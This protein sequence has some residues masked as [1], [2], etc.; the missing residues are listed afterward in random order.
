MRSKEDVTPVRSYT[1]KELARLYAPGL[2]TKAAGNRLAYWLSYCKPLWEKL[3]EAGY[4]PLQR[5]LT[6]E[7]VRLIF[8][9]LG[10]P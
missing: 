2:T 5:N 10:E 4:R 3:Q 8:E 7:Q 6:P 1:K 9:Y